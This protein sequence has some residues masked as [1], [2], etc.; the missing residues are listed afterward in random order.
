MVSPCESAGLERGLEPGDT[1]IAKDL[2]PLAPPAPEEAFITLRSDKAP[3]THDLR[4]RANSGRQTER[5]SPC[6][7]CQQGC[8]STVRANAMSCSKPPVIRNRLRHSTARRN[9]LASLSASSP[10]SSIAST[11]CKAYKERHGPVSG[12]NTPLQR[13]NC[14]SSMLSYFARNVGRCINTFH[15]SSRTSADVEGAS[16][17]P[18]RR[19]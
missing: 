3:A 12:P 4:I 10:G 5:S 1:G 9:L 17:M 18:K 2:P 16:M 13:V 15:T 14:W 8:L 11:I 6:R 7:W 19:L